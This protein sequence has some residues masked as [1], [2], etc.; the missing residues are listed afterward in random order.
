ME[1]VNLQKT[2]GILEHHDGT[3]PKESRSDILQRQRNCKSK[4]VDL[5]KEF[6]AKLMD[7][8]EEEAKAFSTAFTVA[9]EIS[10]SASNVEMVDA[11]SP[12]MAES[13]VAAKDT[14]SGKFIQITPKPSQTKLNHLPTIQ[15]AFGFPKEILTSASQVINIPDAEFLGSFHERPRSLLLPTPNLRGML[16]DTMLTTTLGRYNFMK[17]TI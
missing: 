1:T 13:P 9:P 2:I 16:Q 6:A 8:E 14:P 4:I 11:S 15:N 10:A 7:K 12:I 17:S 3:E 5:Q